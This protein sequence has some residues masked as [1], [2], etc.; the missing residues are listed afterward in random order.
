MRANVKK[1]GKGA[2]ISIPPAILKETSLK[3]GDRIDIRADCG[4]IVIESIRK[5]VRYDIGD[6]VAG[7]TAEN[8]HRAVNFGP[9]VGQEAW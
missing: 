1:F 6:L 5:P 9:A 7:I 4:R 3:I 2:G 8:L